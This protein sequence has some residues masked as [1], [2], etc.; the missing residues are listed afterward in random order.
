MLPATQ[1]IARYIGS[2]RSLDRFSMQLFHDLSNVVI[3]PP[4]RRILRVEN[5][6]DC[7]A[8]IFQPNLLAS[9][10]GCRCGFRF[11]TLSFG[12]SSL[13]NLYIPVQ[14][15][16]MDELLSFTLKL[17]LINANNRWVMTTSRSKYTL[18]TIPKS[19]WSQLPLPGIEISEADKTGA[20]L[21]CQEFRRWKI[22]RA[23]ASVWDACHA[24]YAI[25]V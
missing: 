7:S 25:Q 21:L 6:I 10:A 24:R 9:A 1:R 8:Q 4:L 15:I 11:C 14:Q 23:L 5:L 18:W 16:Q 22:E 3:M 2:A 20:D 13:I 19:E 17:K 12:G